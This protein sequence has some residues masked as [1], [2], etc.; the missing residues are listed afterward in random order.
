V[1]INRTFKRV[2]HVDGEETPLDRR[3]H[4]THVQLLRKSAKHQQMTS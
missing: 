3:T 4:V 2:F 1:Y